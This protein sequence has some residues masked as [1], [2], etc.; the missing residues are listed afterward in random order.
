[1]ATNLGGF[2]KALGEFGAGGFG[3]LLATITILCLHIQSQACRVLPNIVGARRIPLQPQQ[4][5][6]GFLEGVAGP[7]GLPSVMWVAEY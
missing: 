3:W 7:I 2:Q 1:M 6:L 5:P 4:A